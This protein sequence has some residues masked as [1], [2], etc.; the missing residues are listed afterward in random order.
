MEGF[1]DNAPVPDDLDGLER[2]Y[3]GKGAMHDHDHDDEGGHD[4]WEA[5]SDFSVDEEFAHLEEEEMFDPKNAVVVENDQDWST[6]LSTHREKHNTGGKGVL[7]DYEEAKRITRRRNETKALKQREAWKKAGYG[8]QEIKES[9]K[10]QPKSKQR[11]EESESDDDDEDEFFEK[12]RA[13]R[14]QQLSSVAGLPQYGTLRSVSKFQFVDEVDQ[15]DKRT[16]VVIHIYEDYLLACQ[17]MNKILAS[18]ASRYPHVNFL[19]LKAT[20]ADQTL[21]HSVLPAFLVYKGGNLA[22]HAA[23]KAE[24]TEFQNEKFNEDDVEFF[25]ASKYG[26]QLPGV[27]VSE[28]ERRRRQGETESGGQDE[29]VRNSIVADG[30]KAFG[31]YKA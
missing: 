2:K 8:T 26:V 10:P 23:I 16:F 6:V 15:A 25:L 14:L 31:R 12:F 1:K 13:L 29:D 24:R 17:R 11:T 19:M 7:A 21:S 30:S 27:D 5:T 4:Q 22:G 9:S 20:E 18:L 3:L 28:Q